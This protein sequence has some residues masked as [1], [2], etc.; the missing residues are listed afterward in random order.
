MVF[1]GD[2]AYILKHRQ[3]IKTI[4]KINN[5]YPIALRPVSRQT[6]SDNKQQGKVAMVLA[7]ALSEL[8]INQSTPTT[9]KPT[10]CRQKPTCATMCDEAFE[11]F[12]SF[13]D[14]DSHVL[15]H[16]SNFRPTGQCTCM[17]VP[18]KT[19][20]STRAP[21]GASYRTAEKEMALLL[22]NHAR[23]QAHLAKAFIGR[24]NLKR[25]LH[26]TFAHQSIAP[27]TRLYKAAAEAYGSAFTSAPDLP[28]DE[29]MK[30]KA[31]RLPQKRR[32]QA[33]KRE[34][35]GDGAHGSFYIDIY[36]MPYPGE[37]GERYGVLMT[38]QRAIYERAIRSKDEA[39]DA[40]IDELSVL[41][42]KRNTQTLQLYFSDM[43]LEIGDEGAG[44]H[45]ENYSQIKVIVSDGAPE[46]LRRW[47]TL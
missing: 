39:P 1:V 22:V 31:H 46:L 21:T 23:H 37:H 7:K 47:R 25:L 35:T 40:I 28:C 19:S 5:L 29:C 20:L 27:G 12:G 14:D 13:F 45:T 36:S 30:H 38:D 11:K 18:I 17:T 2:S 26:L 42:K 43:Q 33:E 34:A 3:I 8:C 32:T 24:T 6:Q 41:A 15:N 4:S 16:A 10:S 44:E 9:A